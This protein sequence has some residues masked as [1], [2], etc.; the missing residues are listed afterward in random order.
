MD[1]QI[2]REGENEVKHTATPWRVE[3]Y[4]LWK[5]FPLAMCLALL[6]A[7]VREGQS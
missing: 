4:I 5:P 7:K 2:K 1:T 3:A 6:T